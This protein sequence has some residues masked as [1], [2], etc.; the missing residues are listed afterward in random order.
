MKKRI[1]ITGGAGF[2]GSHLSEILVNEEHDVICVD[3]FFSGDKGNIKHLLDNPFFEL[4]RHDVT[5]P[6]LCRS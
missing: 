3:N 5:F 1:L 6:L 4:L 2:L